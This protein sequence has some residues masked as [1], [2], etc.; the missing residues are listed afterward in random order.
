MRDLVRRG[1]YV[2][3]VHGQEEMEADGLSLPDV[4]HVV[5][6]GAI[7]ERQRDQRTGE[8]KY[9][10]EG[11]SLNERRTSVAAKIGHTGR[12]VIITVYLSIGEDES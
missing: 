10:V 11:S 8:A 1:S 6:T 7:L 12:L 5:L 3:T 2:M 4:E 9:V